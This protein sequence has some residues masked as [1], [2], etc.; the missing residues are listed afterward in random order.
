MSSSLLL[1][2]LYPASLLALCV[3]IH[4]SVAHAYPQGIVAYLTFST[5]NVQ[6]SPSE[7]KI[8]KLLPGVI[9][10]DITSLGKGGW[11]HPP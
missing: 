9:Q 11:L 10:V 1:R 8:L 2:R 6:L 3:V 5:G 7:Q 4:P